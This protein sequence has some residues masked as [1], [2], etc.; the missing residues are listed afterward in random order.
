M[1]ESNTYPPYTHDWRSSARVAWICAATLLPVVA[2]SSVLFGRAAYSVWAVAVASA[3]VAEA[4]GSALLRRWTLGDGSAVMTGLLVA[5]AMPPGVP[6]Y[7]PALAAAFAILV[8]KTA[9]GGLGANWMNPA[10]GGIAFAYANWP[11]AMREFVLPSV[12]SG[13]D[14]V[15]AATPLSFA[16]GLTSGLPGRVMDAMRGAGYPLSGMDE[17]VTRFLNDAV[18]ARLG[19]RLPE[20]YIDLALGFKPGAL[21]ESA[22]FA[23]LAGSILLVSLRLIKARIPFAMLATFAVLARV[24]GTGLP[25]EEFLGGDALYALS[26]GGIALAAFY[27]AVDPVTSPVGSLPSLLFGVMLGLLCFAFRR[28]GAYT[29]GV[30]YAILIMNVAGPAMEKALSALRSRKAGAV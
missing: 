10:L 4:L 17:A 22:L 1:M 3:L 12:V 19:A 5:S 28:W 6:L 30:A 23:V 11:E 16:T 29:E 27:M 8:V 26:G 9:F 24:F 13:V 21:G 20:G 25:G 18:F 2:W 7:I 14:G 15:S